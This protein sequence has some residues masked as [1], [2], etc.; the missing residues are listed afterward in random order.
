MGPNGALG[1][2]AMLPRV[3]ANA[4][5]RDAIA[6]AKFAQGAFSRLSM[7]TEYRLRDFGRAVP[8]VVFR[9]VRLV[10]AGLGMTG[11]PAVAACGA[12]FPVVGRR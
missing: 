3:L 9:V 10:R 4:S 5:V 7:G 11:H 12:V 2:L 6:L 8:A 1:L